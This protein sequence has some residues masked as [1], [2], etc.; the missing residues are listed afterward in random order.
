MG[1][2]T[3]S[4]EIKAAL[5]NEGDYFKD[6]YDR[7]AKHLKA[8]GIDIDTEKALTLGVELNFDIETEAVVDNDQ[9][10]QLMARKGRVGFEIPD[11]TMKSAR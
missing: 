6:S 9:A 4:D 3:T 8:N 5:E 10:S 1:E 11:M 7:L 2:K